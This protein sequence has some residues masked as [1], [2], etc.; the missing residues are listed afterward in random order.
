MQSERINPGVGSSAQSPFPEGGAASALRPEHQDS[1][2]FGSSSYV[3]FTCRGTR[4]RAGSHPPT[5]WVGSIL[6]DCN[7]PPLAKTG[8]SRYYCYM[9]SCETIVATGWVKLRQHEP[10]LILT[11]ENGKT[12]RGIVLSPSPKRSFVRYNEDGVLKE[13]RVDNRRLVLISTSAVARIAT[14][15]TDA[16]D[17]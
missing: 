17:E 2:P 14:E 5:N 11:E 3:V 12:W 7:Q 10:V 13:Q 16:T 15:I 4:L 6:G 8:S 1:L 9:R